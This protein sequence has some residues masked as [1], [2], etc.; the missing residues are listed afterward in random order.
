MTFAVK[1]AAKTRPKYGNLVYS[2]PDRAQS[3]MR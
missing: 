2:F 3:W 1:V